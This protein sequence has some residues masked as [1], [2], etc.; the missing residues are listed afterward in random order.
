MK[1]ILLITLTAIICLFRTEFQSIANAKVMPPLYYDSN[2]PTDNSPIALQFRYADAILI[3]NV[4]NYIKLLNIQVDPTF[5]NS[6]GQKIF[7][8]FNDTYCGDSRNTKL[9]LTNKA[10]YSLIYIIFYQQKYGGQLSRQISLFTDSQKKQ[11][12]AIL[13]NIRMASKLYGTASRGI[14]DSALDNQYNANRLVQSMP[15]KNGLNFAEAV[16]SKI[17]DKMTFS[18]RYYISDVF[19]HNPSSNTNVPKNVQTLYDSDQ[20]IEITLNAVL[21]QEQETKMQYSN[22][23]ASENSNTNND[24][25]FFKW[26]TAGLEYSQVK[27]DYVNALDCFT[28]A[29]N[30][31]PSKGEAWSSRGGMKNIL[32]DY[33]GAIY[34]YS[35]AIKLGYQVPQNYYNRAF[36]KILLGQYKGAEEDFKKTYSLTKG[37][38]SESIGTMS[39]VYAEQLQKGQGEFLRKFFKNPYYIV[40][41]YIKENGGMSLYG[42]P[43]DPSKGK[44]ESKNM[45][46]LQQ[47]QQQQTPQTSVIPIGCRVYMIIGRLK[48][49]HTEVRYTTIA[50]INK[51]QDIVNADPRF[52]WVKYMTVPDSYLDRYPRY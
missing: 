14:E 46:Q 47:Q 25:L 27:K 50:Q 26:I 41:A 18:A 5:T 12:V 13:Y 9:T 34:D 31:N 4:N 40:E 37:T 16:S 10:F 11:Y 33:S 21:P 23:L 43:F 32:G 20:S 49:S 42:N 48:D 22:M 28:K 51:I 8:E 35:Q 24:D 52:E 30:I 3:T 15:L 1:K 44:S 29:I 17:E 19:N 39:M 2:F 45:Q 6:D 7:D 36:S 38:K